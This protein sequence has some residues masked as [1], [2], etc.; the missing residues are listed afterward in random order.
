MEDYLK[1]KINFK[2]PNFYNEFV[3]QYNSEIKSLLGNDTN[4]KN[5]LTSIFDSLVVLA[6]KTNEAVS[7]FKSLDQDITQDIELGYN[8]VF[9]LIIQEVSHLNKELLKNNLKNLIRV[10]NAF[11]VQPETE[12]KFESISKIVYLIKEKEISKKLD[13]K[14]LSFLVNEFKI[15]LNFVYYKVDGDVE[16]T[17]LVQMKKYHNRANNQICSK[18]RFCLETFFDSFNEEEFTNKIDV[19]QNFYE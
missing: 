14:E 9:K 16:E 18:W 15:K 2:S 17:E 11:S 1:N 19:F 10:I 13:A 7:Y 12:F 6:E 4:D 8:Q 5:L 3:D